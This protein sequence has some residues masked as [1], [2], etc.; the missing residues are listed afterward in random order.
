MSESGKPIPWAAIV[1]VGSFVL[2]MIGVLAALGGLKAALIGLVAA[3]LIFSLMLGVV[4]RARLVGSSK[5]VPVTPALI[6]GLF[7]GM[8]VVLVLAV[9]VFILK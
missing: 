4:W 3:V 8:I 6:A 5:S 9:L 2:I 1:L 7:S